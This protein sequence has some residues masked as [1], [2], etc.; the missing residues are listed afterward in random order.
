MR[1]AAPF[2]I[3]EPCH[4]LTSAG[5]NRALESIIPS[6]QVPPAFNLVRSRVVKETVFNR[7]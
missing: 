6:L 7:R 3:T 2:L 4:T 5:L 1:A